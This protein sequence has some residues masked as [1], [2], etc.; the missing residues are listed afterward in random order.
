MFENPSSISTLVLNSMTKYWSELTVALSGNPYK[1]FHRYFLFL[2]SG[3]D[4]LWLRI[5]YSANGQFYPN[6]IILTN[7]IQLYVTGT[8]VICHTLESFQEW[9]HCTTQ[10]EISCPYSIIVRHKIHG[11][12]F[13]VLPHSIVKLNDEFQTSKI[14]FRISHYWSQKI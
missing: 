6:K 5:E 12:A 14:S 3:M 9:L 13:Y 1:P 7:R 11:P 2:A 8:T 10:F 4:V